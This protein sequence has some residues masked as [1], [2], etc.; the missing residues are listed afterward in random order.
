MNS[1]FKPRLAAIALLLGA[2]ALPASADSLLASSAAGGSSASSASSASSDK[3]SD[4]SKKTK[5]AAGPYR[6]VDVA[7]L[8][9][10]PGMLRVQLQALAAPGPAGDAAVEFILYL[11]QP[12]FERSHLAV[13]DAVT[14]RARPYG[15]EFADAG[16]DKAFFLVV[17]DDWYRELAANPL[18]L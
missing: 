6:I 8:P 4:S 11:P 17:D 16:T 1:R 13:G 12:A 15:T 2:C 7:A 9:E 5:T 14:A 18:R 3:S 10:R